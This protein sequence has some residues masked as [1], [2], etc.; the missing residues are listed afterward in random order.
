[1]RE[2]ET[3]EVGQAVLAL[4]LID[5]ELD[6]AEAVVLILLEI[7]EGSLEDTALQGVVGVLETGGAVDE[8]LADTGRVL[9]RYSGI[10]RSSF[11]LLPAHAL[12]HSLA[13]ALSRCM[14]WVG[15]G[16]GVL[17][18]GE[19][20]GCLDGVPVLLS[21]GVGPL[22]QALLAL[23]QSLVL[24]NRHFCGMSRSCR[25]VV[26][27]WR[28]RVNRSSDVGEAWLRVVWKVVPRAHREKPIA[29][30]RRPACT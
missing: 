3:V 21:E 4:D 8:G 30:S 26:V 16:G 11:F 1:V 25:L 7:G 19:S 10:P 20:G 24:A 17:S 29:L 15:L 5:A 28:R 22:L 9:V 27:V 6:L 13:I 23:G 14:D 12:L 2:V 18:D